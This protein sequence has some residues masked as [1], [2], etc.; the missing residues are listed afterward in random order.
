MYSRAHRF[1]LFG[2]N[3]GRCI[4][5]LDVY[6]KNNGDEY[7]KKND[8][9]KNDKHKYTM[10]ALLRF[11]LQIIELKTTKKNRKTYFNFFLYRQRCRDKFQN[12]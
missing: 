4:E 2:A 8:G 7:E 11:D 10:S 6:G 12:S 5:A 9:T 3:C 1:L